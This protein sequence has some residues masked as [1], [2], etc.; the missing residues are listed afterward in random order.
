[1]HPIQWSRHSHE[2]QILWLKNGNFIILHI[3]WDTS[4]NVPEIVIL[5]MQMKVWAFGILFG[6]DNMLKYSTKCL[7][8]LLTIVSTVSLINVFVMYWFQINIPLSSFSAVR[9]TFVALIEKRYYLI[10][11]S[12]LICVL[13]FL[14][15]LSVRRQHI[16]LPV[17]S[18]MYLIYDFVIV[19]SL[20]VDGLGDGYLKTYI[21]QTIVSVT[22]IVLLSVCLLDLL[23]KKRAS[24]RQE[25]VLC[26]NRTISVY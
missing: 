25:T 8:I 26:L 10:L 4:K 9:L 17:L 2:R 3:T 23:T 20:L 21:I 6:G 7:T 13:L 16:L 1:M 12:A 5:I 14:S 24:R 11:V 18:L 15:T 19:F 22:L